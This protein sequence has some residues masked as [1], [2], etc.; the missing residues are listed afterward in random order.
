MAEQPT[1]SPWDPGPDRNASVE[2]PAFLAGL[3][4]RLAQEVHGRWARQRM[5]EGWR[6]GAERDEALKTTPNL[7]PY[8]DLPEAE[9][10]VDRGTALATLRAI[11]S[12]GY[13]LVPG[14]SAPRDGA[15]DRRAVEVLLEHPGALGFEA[16]ESL[17][18]SRSPEFWAENPDL[19][20][21]LAQRASDAGWPLMVFD[22]VSQ[23]LARGAT[24]APEVVARLRYLEVLSLVEIGALERAAEELVKIGDC[25]GIAGDLQGLRG[26]LA[27]MRGLRAAS[28]DEARACFEEAGA[29]YEDAYR[30]ARAEFLSSGNAAS[31]EAAYYLGINA[32]TVG[33]WAGRGGEALA[34]EVLELCDRA[35]ALGAGGPW[36]EATRGE[37]HLLL[38]DQEGA[39]AAYRAA[40]KALHGQWRPLQSMRRQALE[41]ARRTGFSE[42]AVDGWFQLPGLHVAGLGEG[43]EGEPPPGSI[44]F[45]YLSDPRQL[46]RAAALAG[47]AAEFHLGTEEP[48]DVFRARLSPGQAAL[49]DKV[50][51]GAARVLGQNE[52]CASG[53]ECT[54]VFTKLFFRGLALLR[55]RELDTAPR[56]LPSL[57]DCGA[58]GAALP[59]RAL[60]CAD[61]KGY[62]RLGA[63]GLRVFC[64]DFLGCVGDVVGNYR[65]NTITVKTVGDGLFVAFR[66]VGSAIRCGLALRDATA[67]VDWAARGFPEDL[68]LR[69]SLDAGPVMEFVDPVTG[70][71]DVAG[72]LVNRAARIE[73]VTPV[74]HVYA[75]RTMAALATA[76]EIPGARFEYAGE[77]AL[78]KGYGTFPLYH[79]TGA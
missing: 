9:K 57:A 15:G 32:A 47:N 61:A 48:A 73:P 71:T 27:K 42:Q 79:L 13:S 30:A 59:F 66:D 78:P 44:V 77:T 16:A 46:E 54:P 53:A 76:L 23:A 60:L 64:R 45:F 67:A 65:D 41:T 69:I 74:H 35:Q 25:A 12:E 34:R 68:G 4:E 17:R 24:G 58:G 56:G 11:L 39:G 51:G 18:R 37:A 3:T 19:L 36:L 52:I 63:D 6:F 10:D 38:R 14:G 28:S 33:A 70:R 72:Q 29:T 8:D 5:S 20:L 22:M 49:F 62:S 21:H 26:R 31:A 43:A 40:A 55:A 50:V 75:S 1:K 7:V 2:L